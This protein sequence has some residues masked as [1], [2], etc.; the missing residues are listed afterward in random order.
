MMQSLFLFAATFG[1]IACGSDP[2]PKVFIEPTMVPG[3]NALWSSCSEILTHESDLSI[4]LTIGGIDYTVGSTL[5]EGGQGIV[6]ELNPVTSS[7]YD[8]I[9]KYSKAADNS[10]NFY[11]DLLLHSTLEILGVPTTRAAMGYITNAGNKQFVL[12]KERVRGK[13]LDKILAK[14]SFVS[15]FHQKERKKLRAA[16]MIFSR[17]IN[18]GVY[19]SDMHSRNLMWD[20][21]KKNLIMLDGNIES[22]TEHPRINPKKGFGRAIG[23][24]G[25]LGDRVFY[26]RYYSTKEK[27]PDAAVRTALERV[28]LFFN[29][30]QKNCEPPPAIYKDEVFSIDAHE[31]FRG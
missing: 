6:K 16:G 4:I 1:F 21:N 18:A 8:L 20:V 15:F 30:S 14:T 28:N 12:I 24:L 10:M 25:P 11:S 22:P 2:N 13:T 29:S 17:I 23:I 5:G 26:D 7:P 3:A 27:A 19:I 31:V 9:I